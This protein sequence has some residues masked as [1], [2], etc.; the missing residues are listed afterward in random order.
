MPAG[1]RVSVLGPVRAWSGDTELALGHARRRAVFAVLVARANQVVS[2]QELVDAVW[3]EAPPARVVGSLHTYVSGLRRVLGPHREALESR[4][5][6]Y[7]LRLADDAADT[8]RFDRARDHGGRLS[9]AGR[10]AEARDAFEDALGLWHGSAYAGLP[11]PFAERERHRLAELR[12]GVAERRARARLELGEHAEVV[13]DLA[14]LVAE[15]PWHESLRELVMVALHR[16]GRRAE[17]LEAFQD[18]RR[19]LVAGQGV[20]PGPALR[21]LHRDILAGPSGPLFSAPGVTPGGVFVGRDDDTAQLRELVSDVLAGRGT[22]VW[23]EGEAGIGKSALLAAAL[24]DAGDR[25]CQVAWAVADEL[26]RRNPLRVVLDCLAVHPESPD[27]RRADLAARLRG[28]PDPIDV[29]AAVDRL[30]ALVDQA[31]ATAPLVLVIDDL[32]WADDASVLLWHRLAAATRQLP[33]LLVA[34]T[35]PDPARRELARVRRA[36]EAHNGYVL[37]LGPLTTADAEALL[38]RTVGAPAG[39]G[40]REVIGFAAGN[41]LYLTE[42]AHALVRGSA[43]RVVGGVAEVDPDAAERVPRSLSAAVERTLDLLSAETREVLRLAALLGARFRVAELT[44][45][46]GRSPLELVCVLDEAV[47]AAVVVEAGDDLAF[48]HPYLRQVLHE[49]VPR[50]MR[51]ALH[52]HAA[53]ALAGTGVPVERVAGHLVAEEIPADGWVV[54]WLADHHAAVAA[55]APGAAAELLR[56]A[57][58]TDLPTPAQRACLLT[59]LV[60]ARF[61]VGRF[62]EADAERALA[63]TTDPDQAAEL[64]HL[65][66]AMRH[67]RGD[68]ATAITLLGEALDAPDVPESWRLRHVALLA[69]FQRGDLDDLDRTRLSAERARARAVD[70]H[71]AARAAQTLWLVRSIRRDH[72][73]ALRHVD[74]ALAVVGDRPGLAELRFDL[75]DNRVFSLQNLDRLDEAERALRG[76][77]DPPTCLQV[78]AAVHHHWTGRWDEALAGLDALAEDGTGL[79]GLREPGPTTL[80]VHGVAALI[81]GHRDDRVAATAHL[82]AAREH[83]AATRAEREN[84]DFHLAAEA[85]AA[86]Q[87]GDVV[88]ALAHLAPALRPDYAPMMLRHQ[89]LPLVIRLA[90]TVDD[91]ATARTALA[92]CEEEAA[93][94]VVPARAHAA[95]AHCRG[96]LADDPDPVLEAAAHYRSV[97]RVVECATALEDAGVLL[98]AAGRADEASSAFAEAVESF[99]AL[100]ARWDVHRA[101]SRRRAAGVVH[102]PGHPPAKSGWQA[103]SPLE[104]RIAR[105]VAAGLSNPDI[106]GELALPRRTVQSHVARLTAKLRTDSRAGITGHVHA[107]SPPPA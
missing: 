21:E 4:P 1:L 49:D 53:E 88:G 36:V 10:W 92:V 40:L 31:C 55:R 57:V 62:P 45:V 104:V 38:A 74:D 101:E 43:V 54:R 50:P 83:T 24:A 48:R 79:F 102:H 6:G 52:R 66:A 25:G 73:R 77:P 7:S 98:A 11:G 27:P 90:L 5:H 9:A 2:R 19:A 106:A 72:G 20:E 22:A 56:R 99:G 47:A 103:L 60:R 95:A 97:G 29:P 78:T 100:S 30:A 89:W 23:V 59:A 42:V 28:D 86:E 76:V 37:A 51:V 96:L 33:L 91:H 8:A 85:L 3:G 13:A 17:A 71:P 32:H 70:A 82:T 69:D 26:G 44:A 15:H 34:A 80:L 35:R 12:L 94:E 16:S 107:N 93:K 58:D 64:R 61:R 14:E 41:P 84:C 39:E 68:P 46:T 87:R 105:L 18:A 67:R 65:R 63:L 75:L 81:A